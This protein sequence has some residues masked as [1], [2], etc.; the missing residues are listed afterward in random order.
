L[1]ENLQ[2][3]PNEIQVKIRFRSRM[4]Q[5]YAQWRDLL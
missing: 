1:C 5:H 4:V 2:I 3:I